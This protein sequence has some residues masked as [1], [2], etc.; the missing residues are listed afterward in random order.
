MFM[1]M[2][3]LNLYFISN[4]PL[5]SSSLRNLLLVQG[6]WESSIS[7]AIRCKKMAQGRALDPSGANQ[8]VATQSKPCY[9]AQV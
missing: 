2:F 8:H 3:R 1:L 5:S 4:L 6:L 9:K 7:K